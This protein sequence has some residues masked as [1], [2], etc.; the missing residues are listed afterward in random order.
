[1]VYPMLTTT[2]PLAAYQQRWEQPDADPA[3]PS[4]EEPEASVESFDADGAEVALECGGGIAVLLT[5]GSPEWDW[6]DAVRGDRVT[7]Q[8]VDIVGYTHVDAAVFIDGEQVRA[9]PDDAELETLVGEARRLVDGDIAELI[10][11]RIEEAH[12]EDMAADA[13]DGGW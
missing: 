6:A 5:L 10:A 13:A 2:H 4:S 8:Y 3:G 7:G 12:A 1:M 9:M 11:E